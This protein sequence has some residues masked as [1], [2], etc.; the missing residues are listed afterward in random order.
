MAA[1]DEDRPATNE[2][3]PATNEGRPATNEDRPAT[4]EDRPAT[5]EG[6]EDRG[7]GGAPPTGA[8]DHGRAQDPGAPQGTA[9]DAA[10]REQ[11]RQ[12]AEGIESPG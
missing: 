11:E 10:E 8:P 7:D 3:R 12:L 9:A 4:N 1:S 6:A 5:D 2:G